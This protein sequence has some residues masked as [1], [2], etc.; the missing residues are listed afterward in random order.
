MNIFYL[1]DI[2]EKGIV[3]LDQEESKHL[4]KVLRLTRGELVYLTNGKGQMFEARVADPSSREATLEILR[5]IDL[6]PPRNFNIH[7]AVAPT[8]NIDRIEWF[9]EKSVEMGIEEI[10]FI[11]TRRSERKHINPERMNKI[12]VS[13]MK[14]S[15]KPYLPVVNDL[16]DFSK[17]ISI[18]D[19]DQKFIAHLESPATIHLKKQAVAG[20]R[21]LVLIGPEGDFTSEEID[22]ARAAGFSD[23]TLGPYRLRTETAALTTCNI[24]N[25]INQE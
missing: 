21:Y 10:S 1:P 5:T 24:L 19:A 17:F 11:R 23:A 13:A 18:A 14:Q 6:Y 3:S 4:A 22:A 25:L 15:M 12:A 2:K 8:K 16:T 7:I 20:S 9:V